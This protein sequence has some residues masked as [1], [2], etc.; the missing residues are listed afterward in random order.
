MWILDQNGTGI[1]NTETCREIAMVS[2]FEICIANGVG[3]KDKNYIT[4]ALYSDRVKAREVFY[5]TVHALDSE[6]VVVF[7]MPKE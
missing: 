7:K 4:L 1:Y 3:M 5:E 2:D 6:K